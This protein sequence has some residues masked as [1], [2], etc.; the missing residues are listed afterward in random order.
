M[1]AFGIDVSKH[2]GKIDWPQVAASGVRFAILR[3]GYGNTAAQADPY[4]AANYEGAKAAGLKV[5]AYWYSYASG[6]DDAD[7]EAA[8][9]LQVLAGRKLDLPL[10][11]DQE[12]EPA[13]LSQTTAGRTACVQRSA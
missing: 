5:G 3:A 13:I 7:S 2:Q 8:A 9:C 10:F 4:F 1:N 6:P 11:F 12:Y